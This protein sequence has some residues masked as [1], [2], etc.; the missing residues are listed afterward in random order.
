MSAM[1]QDGPSI[2]LQGSY[3][4]FVSILSCP[5][6]SLVN[7]HIHHWPYISSVWLAVHFASHLPTHAS[8]S[9]NVAVWLLSA[10]YPI[11]MYYWGTGGTPLEAGYIIQ[12]IS[13]RL[14]LAASK[15]FDCCWPSSQAIISL[16]D[17]IRT[18][19]RG[20]AWLIMTQTTPGTHLGLVTELHY[21]LQNSTSFMALLLGLFFIHLPNILCRNFAKFST[22]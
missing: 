10:D 5:H 13:L 4:L 1:P 16:E 12:V 14:T 19:R 20:E 2:H 9:Y 17:G 22:E 8:R 15:S 11:D 7:L 18:I 6:V 21:T 3:S